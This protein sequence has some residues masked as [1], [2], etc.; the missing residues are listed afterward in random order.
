MGGSIVFV[1]H[2][3][4][5]KSCSRI[6]QALVNNDVY[7]REGI[8]LFSDLHGVEIE[9]FRGYLSWQLKETP[10]SNY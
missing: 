4:Y 8:K 6:G 5:C 3:H 2:T 10:T 7:V 9:S 1:D